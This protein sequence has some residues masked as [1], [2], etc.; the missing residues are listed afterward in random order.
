MKN[1]K[2][3]TVVKAKWSGRGVEGKQEMRSDKR[4]GAYRGKTCLITLCHIWVRVR[5]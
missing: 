4:G 2:E 3:A 1:S 5:V